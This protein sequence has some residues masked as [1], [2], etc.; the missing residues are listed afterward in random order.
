MYRRNIAL[1]TDVRLEAR[2]RGYTLL[3]IVLV[4][5]VIGILMMAVFPTFTGSRDIRLLDNAANQIQ[6]TMQM[7]KW[8]A[9][10]TSLNHRIRFSSSDNVWTYRIERESTSGAWTLVQGTTLT[11][12]STTLEVTVNLPASLDVVFQ[13]TGFI[14]NYDS[15]K[16]SITLASPKLRT[17]N[18]SYRRI[19]RIFAG[20]SVHCAKT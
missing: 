20:G 17:L 8:K 14:S 9:A 13:P 7:A 3:E 6:M 11:Q 15:T 16:S 1:P 10:D 2:L 19:V 12:I 5:A 18:Q 4:L